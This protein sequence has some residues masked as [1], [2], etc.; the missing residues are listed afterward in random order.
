MRSSSIY[1]Y[2]L[3][4]EK[5]IPKYLNTAQNGGVIDILQPDNRINL[6]HAYDGAKAALLAYQKN[7]WGVFNNGAESY[8]LAE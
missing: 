7:S 6:I 1:G 4:A 2:G 3:S 5:S 8:S